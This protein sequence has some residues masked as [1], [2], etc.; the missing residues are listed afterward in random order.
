MPRARVPPEP[1]I[2]T[3]RVQIRGGFAA[4]ADSVPMSRT[5]CRWLITRLSR[6]SPGRRRTQHPP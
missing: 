4:P 6:S 5:W 2:Y 1:P 3:V